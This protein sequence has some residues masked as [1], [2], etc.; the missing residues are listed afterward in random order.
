M[1]NKNSGLLIFRVLLFLFASALVLVA[2]SALTGTIPAPWRD[3]LLAASAAVGTLALTLLF[4]RWDHVTVRDVGAAIISGSS[5]RFALGFLIGIALVACYAT[6]TA[7]DG[8]IL[9][10]RGARPIFLPALIN[11]STYFA[12][13]CRE[14][15]AFRGYPLFR[16]Q[17]S[18]GLWTAQFVVAAA[19]AAEHFVAGWPLSRAIL[20]AGIG[21]LLFGMAAIAT[22][23]LALPI[24]LHTAWNFADWILGGKDATGLWR[25]VIDSTH[26]Q[27]A[28]AHSTLAY[29]ATMALATGAFWRY[30][31]SQ[32]RR[33][34]P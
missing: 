15:L 12:L 3:L 23:G 8:H 20:G 34:R 30:H 17:H 29:I 28:Q 2:S 25:R 13:A 9:W 6:L 27:S 14:E 31:R 24:G 4:V 32:L 18:Y 1:Q 11:L 33:S 21:S 26:E 22:R 5:V 7:L 19:F 10:I 16:L